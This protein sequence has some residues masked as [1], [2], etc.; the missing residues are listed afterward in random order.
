MQAFC[1][2]H[3]HIDLGEDVANI[4]MVYVE[5]DI[6]PKHKDIQA[7]VIDK[8]KFVVEDA[9]QSAM[10]TE[11]DISLQKI[12]GISEKKHWVALVRLDSTSKDGYLQ[13]QLAQC[14]IDYMPQTSINVKVEI[15]LPKHSLLQMFE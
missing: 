10:F 13:S 8:L 11:D 9:C 3:K 4:A 14:K 15:K 6:N 1:P 5:H 2:V 7:Q 12:V